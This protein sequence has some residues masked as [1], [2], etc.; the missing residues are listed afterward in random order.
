MEKFIIPEEKIERFGL[1]FENICDINLGNNMSYQT[2][3]TKSKADV[4]FIPYLAAIIVFLV[5]FN[6]I[7]LSIARSLKRSKEIGLRKIIGSKR[8]QIFLLFL[9]EAFVITFLALITALIFILCL[10]PAYNNIE[11]V[12][13]GGEQI[14]L[15]MLKD[16]GIY[17]DFI[18]VTIVISLLAGLYPA[19][20]L[21]SIRPLY[22]MKGISRKRGFSHLITR[23]ILMGIQFA[24]SFVSIVFI[25]YFNQIFNNCKS[26]DRNIA[27]D[28][29]VNVFL[30][31]VNYET[32]RNEI[33][34]NSMFTGVSFSA[35]KPLY[36]RW[37]FL[38][39][40][41]EEMDEQLKV[42]SFNVSTEFMD[43]FELE[44]MAGRN[45]PE[46][47][48]TD[49]GNT[50]IV[51]EKTV[52]ALGYD[53]PDKIMG[54]VITVDSN[55]NVKVIGVVRDFTHRIYLENPIVPTV[56]VYWPGGFRYANIR[57]LPE[58]EEKIRASL[59]EIWKKLDRVHPGRFS[60]AND[61][62][63]KYEKS[64]TGLVTIFTWVTGFI[65]LIAIIG[66]LGITAYTTELRVREIS[67]RKVLGAGSRELVYMLSKSY[68]K[69]IIIACL[70]LLPVGYKLS[71]LFIQF[72]FAAVKPGMSLW[73]P[74]AALLFIVLLTVI[75]TGSITRKAANA[76]PVDTLREE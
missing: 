2:P 1:G 24:V 62:R 14:N 3:G 25:L 55:P 69:I 27:Y 36:G 22:A 21:S 33:N 18:L 46:E 23:K 56:L 20:H 54:K 57:Y 17:V 53:S 4:M 11:V 50:V 76:N 58:N 31:E 47:I 5:C 26:Y 42:F 38:N 75:T 16:P 10:V 64:Q 51:N 66:L 28:N 71:D 43:N 72:T 40:K 9:S 63:E 37:Q 49:A 30:G 13:S 59:P 61:V 29:C 8:S 19:L 15:K 74:P 70:I 41:T 7:I 35:V 68:M 32:F 67:I 48:A 52:K 60:F 6:Y 45:F 34:R 44:L 39:M 65:I 12:A 73:I